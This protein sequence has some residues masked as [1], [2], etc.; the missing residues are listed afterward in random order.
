M[1]AALVGQRAKQVEDDRETKARVSRLEAK[2][3]ICVQGAKETKETQGPP[4]TLS[5]LVTSGTNE[6]L[7]RLQ[8]EESKSALA[9]D[10]N[11]RQTEK[12]AF[13]A[14]IT[15]L[16]RERDEWKLAASET[17]LALESC[18]ARER[19]CVSDLSIKDA[20]MRNLEKELRARFEAEILETK[21]VAQREYA[22]LRTRLQE[23]KTSPTELEDRLAESKA[24]G[25]RLASQL[26]ESQAA[27]SDFTRQLADSNSKVSDLSKQLSDSKKAVSEL[28]KQLSDTKSQVS[29]L[30]KQ[31]SDSKKEVS[32]LSQKLSMSK[33]EVSELSKQFSDSKKEVTEFST[34]LSDSKKEV[35]RVSKQ[36][37]DSRDDVVGLNRQL[38]DLG[39]ALAKERNDSQDLVSDLQS[40]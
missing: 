10:I 4:S 26:S 40:S 13:R 18:T 36:L 15:G 5:T 22:L 31:L 32:E 12:N 3:K 23:Q 2:L 33:R 20:A 28:S 8:L 35:L 39:S 17:S 30:S 24:S 6:N 21:N 34:Q 25:L 16:T 38:A 27:L 1:N 29:E 14:Q 7:L 9:V 37:S 11:A 19:K